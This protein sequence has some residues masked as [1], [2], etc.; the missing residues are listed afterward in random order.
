[1]DKGDESV[2]QV[3]KDDELDENKYRIGDD[4]PY[5]PTIEETSSKVHDSSKKLPRSLSMSFRKR[6][7]REKIN[8]NPLNKHC[9][10]QL[11]VP[12]VVF[13]DLTNMKRL[14]NYNIFHRNT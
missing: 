14:N 8:P 11:K 9:S 10:E 13:V 12:S 6:K 3:T 1:M 4:L 7:N 5:T 2:N